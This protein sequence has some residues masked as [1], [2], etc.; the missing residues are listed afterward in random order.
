MSSLERF[1]WSLVQ[2]FVAVLDAGSLMAAARQLGSTQPTLSR[3]VSELERQL[4]TPLFERTG[5]GLVPTSAALAIAEA[6]RQMQDGAGLL[7]RAVLG[8]REATTGTVRITTSESAAMYLLPP[9]VAALRIEEPGIQLEI[10]ASNRVEN[11]LRREAD[12][13]VR[14]VR[15]RQSS[16]ISRKLGEVAIVT[17]AHQSYLAR[18]GVPRA[19]GDLL[20]HRLVGYDRDDT[21]V[22]GFARLGAPVPRT[23][24]ALRTD[25]QLVYAQLVAAGAGLGF[26]GSYVLRH[27]P[28][29]VAVLSQVQIPSLPCYLAV[30]RE[31]RSSKVVRRVFDFFAAHLP[32]G[33]AG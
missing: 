9:V 1:D 15:P 5:R 13:A 29:V 23:A 32:D 7:G 10:V 20:Q 21:I 22:R 31:I 6:A 25:N 8:Q 16:L 2:S 17:C 19:I 4:G 28:G 11:L 12:I 14:M 33:L 30:H 27:L 18:A 26:L 24:F 3:H